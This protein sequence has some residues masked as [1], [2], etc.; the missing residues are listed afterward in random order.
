MGA[1]PRR[2]MLMAPMMFGATGFAAGLAHHEAVKHKQQ[3]TRQAGGEDVV[4]K[5]SQLAQLRESG[6]IDQAEFEAAKQKLL[7]T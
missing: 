5:L 3:A 6:A 7:A 4:E 1:R 2:P